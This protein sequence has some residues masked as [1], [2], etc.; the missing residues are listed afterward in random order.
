MGAGK[1]AGR[2]VAVLLLAQMVAGYLVNFSILTPLTSAPG[3][4]LV[5]AATSP[6]R[7]GLSALLGLAA[8]ASS[9]AIAI[10]VFPIVRRHSVR[11]ALAIVALAGVSLALVAVEHA[12]ILSVLS[13]SQARAAA[14][15]PPADLYE[16]VALLARSLRN[17]AHFTGL[18]FVGC[19]YLAFYGALL[20]HRLVPRA[21]AALGLIAAALQVSSVAQPFFDREV[22]F[23]LLMPMGLSHLLLAGWLL[24][25]GFSEPPA[26]RE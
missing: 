16:T 9:L 22:I 12:G 7:V 5:N 19:M 23:P 17:W 24:V 15:S 18:V 3:G 21:I 2:I 20:R 11:L 6:L 26:G 1:G 4:L 13:L 25:R 10:T 8:G 14:P